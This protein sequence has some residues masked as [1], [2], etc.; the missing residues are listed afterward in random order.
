MLLKGRAAAESFPKKEHK[1][2]HLIPIFVAMTLPKI[3]QKEVLKN[4]GFEHLNR[5]QH[6]TIKGSKADNTILLAPT[7]TGKTVAYL[8]STLPKLDKEADGIQMLILAPTRELAQQ[9]ERVIKAMKLEL[10]SLICYGGHSF[11]QERNSLRT[12]PTILIGTPGR[13]QDHI[14]RDTFTV[15][16]LTIIIFD[17]F[18]KALEIGFS[19]QMEGIVKHLPMLKTRFLVSATQDIDVPDYICLENP[20]IHNFTDEKTGDLKI[21]KHQVPYAQKQ[22]GLLTVINQMKPDER[23][24]VFVNHREMSDRLGEV[25]ENAGLDY[26]VFHGGLE[27]DKRELELTRFRNESSQILIATDIAARGIDIPNLDYV[28]HYQLPGQESVF[29]HRNGRTARMKASGTSVL[30]MTDKDYLPEYL[31][32]EPEDFIIDLNKKLQRSQWVTIHVN[33]G[34]K[35]KVNKMDF[36]GYILNFDFMNKEDLG[37]IEV[38][39]FFSYLAISRKKVPQLLE[40]SKN[41]KIKN[42]QAKFDYART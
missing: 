35:H 9:I 33:R 31:A 29:T 25:L 2:P 13:I 27:Q 5:M 1:P 26:S 22:E 7:G 30:I 42:K 14:N 40:A 24:I 28:I 34:K 15:E 16:N 23:A 38:R 11:S 19:K 18:D 41:K 6:V 8:L 20:I 39:D 17:E 4:L 12:P 3:N 37:L 36:V 21:A 10:K 32:S